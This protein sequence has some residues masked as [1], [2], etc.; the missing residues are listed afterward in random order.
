MIK[1]LRVKAIIKEPYREAISLINAEDAY[2]DEFVDLM[3]F[4]TDF[5]KLQRAS[6]IPTGSS[7]YMPTGWL[8]HDEIATDGFGH[9]FD[10][11]TGYWAFQCCLKNSEKEVDVF[12]QDVLSQ[13][14]ESAIH[15]EVKSDEE[16]ESELYHF[17][18]GHIVRVS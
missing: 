9:V 14:I 2:F 3:P 18:N 15:I 6:L 1:G 8:I 10:I 12:L 4:A 16:D 5:I 11:E 13:L 17:I 7:A